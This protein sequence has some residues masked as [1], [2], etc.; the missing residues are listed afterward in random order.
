MHHQT[1]RQKENDMAILRTEGLKK[2]YG[3]GDSR[4]EALKG[5]DLEVNKGEFVA[6]VGTSGSGKST[7]AKEL[8]NRLHGNCVYLKQDL[9][10]FGQLM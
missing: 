6:I 7:L 1:T 4:V 9:P 2:T 10:C 5:I 3:K 8:A